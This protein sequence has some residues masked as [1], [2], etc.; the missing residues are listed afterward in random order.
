M[1]T[2]CS[3]RR[4][5][6]L[7]CGLLVCIHTLL[8]VSSVSAQ[9]C[10]GNPPAVDNNVWNCEGTGSG[11]LC[12]G[13]CHAGAL[14][15]KVFF[16][17]ASC[18]TL[19]ACRKLPASGGGRRG[20]QTLW[21]TFARRSVCGVCCNAPDSTPQHPFLTHHTVTSMHRLQPQQQHDTAVLGAG[22]QGQTGRRE[23]GWGVMA[24]VE[25]CRHCSHCEDEWS[26]LQWSLRHGAC[27]PLP[28][29]T[30]QLALAQLQSV[31]TASGIRPWAS[32][33]EVRQP[34]P[35]PGARV[36]MWSAQG[37]ATWP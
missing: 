15:S 32:A 31:K 16:C 17:L 14:H 2:Q 23:S 3:W 25:G 8:C 28:Q 6:R 24:G 36:I 34:K 18:W 4:R 27:C 9:A 21:G 1:G 19:H 33:Y 35:Y 10:E 11:A 7:A 30:P 13:K 5:R 26:Q 37:P 22:G 20:S 12:Q 29:V